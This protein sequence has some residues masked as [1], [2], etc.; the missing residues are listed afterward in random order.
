MANVKISELTSNPTALAGTEV[1]PIVQS[2]TTVKTSVQDVINF[3]N[4]SSQYGVT[5]VLNITGSP[6]ATY[7]FS[8][9]FPNTT[10]TNRV[11]SMDMKIA[12]GSGTGG[13][14]YGSL[15]YNLVRNNSSAAFWSYGSA[16][17]NQSSGS[18]FPSFILAG[19]ESNPTI[20]FYV[21][22][23]QTYSVCMTIITV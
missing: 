3:G 11:I 2:G 23:G 4:S 15:F 16:Y 5:H 10:F 21:S 8:T 9:L 6:S 13:S 20:Q 7:S 1:L 12:I 22:S 17:S 14:T 18:P 19:T